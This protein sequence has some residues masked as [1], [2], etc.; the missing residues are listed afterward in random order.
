MDL[1]LYVIVA[2]DLS[3][4]RHP[5]DVVRAA[6]AG[7]ATAV[8]LREKGL[9]DRR[10]FELG[11]AVAAAARSL[12]LFFLVNDRVDLALALAA[13]G[14]HLG[15]DDL[16]AAVA[17]RLLGPKALIGVTVETEAE[18]QAAA[19]AGA[20]YL[21]TGPIYAT[22]TKPDAGAPYGPAIVQRVRR[23]GG[24]PVVAVGGITPDNAAAVV[25][26]GADGV[27]VASAV[28]AAPDVAAA[29]RALRQAIDAA[30][31]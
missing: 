4:D 28:A 15:Q 3:R 7:G 11:Q 9:S 1:S 25:A 29:A 26:A 31:A 13:D 10:F 23:A 30:R 18:A 5:A 14:V 22:T 16:P 24:L 19:A 6:A 20:D 2:S 12:G 27:C 21:G 17:R 8:Q